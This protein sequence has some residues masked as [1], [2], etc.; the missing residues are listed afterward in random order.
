MCI[1]WSSPPLY[2]DPCD[3]FLEPDAATEVLS[4]ILNPI[5]RQGGP[6]S[7]T[8]PPQSEGS[9]LTAQWLLGFF[10][11]APKRQT[12]PLPACLW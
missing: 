12:E 4:L 7:G 6:V 2:L 3:Q 1:A 11:G 8:A 9:G 10:Y 5:C